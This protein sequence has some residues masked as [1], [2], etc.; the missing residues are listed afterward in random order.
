MTEIRK[1]DDEGILYVELRSGQ[2]TE[3]SALGQGDWL[4]KGPLV[5]NEVVFD[6]RT[7]SCVRRTVME[8]GRQS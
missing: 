4:S 1:W 5:V 2:S 3:S 8:A 6:D 7:D